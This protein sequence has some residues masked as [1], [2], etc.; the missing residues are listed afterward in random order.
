MII[1][2][3]CKRVVNVL[4]GLEILEGWNEE[5]HVWKFKAV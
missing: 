4:H 2:D 3:K 5:R 1:C